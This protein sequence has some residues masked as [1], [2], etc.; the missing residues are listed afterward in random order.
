MRPVEMQMESHTS[1]VAH[2]L[3]ARIE[4]YAGTSG[5]RNSLNV[6][7]HASVDRMA[8]AENPSLIK[9]DKAMV[10]RGNA[11]LTAIHSSQKSFKLSRVNCR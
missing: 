6:A 8:S 3:K 7:A 9:T 2:R 10:G 11:I 4:Y 1:G 5:K